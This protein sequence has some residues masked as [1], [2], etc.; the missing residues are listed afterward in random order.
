M[1][2]LPSVRAREIERVLER[3][4]WAARPSGG[5]SHR[6]FCH[7]AIANTVVV[8]FHPGDVNPRLVRKILRD[9]GITIDEFIDEL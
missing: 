5:G 4:G 2:D 3:R 9:A 8:P 7:P 1:P 6:V